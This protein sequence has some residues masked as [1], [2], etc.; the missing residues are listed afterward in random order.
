MKF[1][2]YLQKKGLTPHAASK[3]LGVASSVCYYWCSGRYSP[4][5]RWRKAIAEW[6]RGIVD[7]ESW[8]E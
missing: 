6:S 1:V 2:E 3:E 4:S 7:M 8:P 5:F